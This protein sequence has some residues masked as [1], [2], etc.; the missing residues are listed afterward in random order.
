MART[1]LI[2]EDTLRQLERLTLVSRKLSTGHLRGERRSRRHGQSVDFADY[3]NYVTGDDLRFLDWKIYARLERLF[4]K[5]FLEEED[6]RVYILLDCS[7]SMVFGEPE[8]LLYAKRVAAALGYIC[9]SRMDSLSVYPFAG[10]MLERFGPRRGKVNGA[11]YF[12]FLE[13]V[14]PGGETGMGRV[15]RD[16]AR[17]IRA[18]GL[19]ILL[20][21]FLDFGGYEDGLGDLFGRGFEVVAMHLLSPEELQPDLVGDVRLVDCE[22]GRHTDVSVGRHLLDTY[23]ATLEAFCEGLRQH[24]IRRGGHYLLCS[25]EVPFDRLVLNVLMRRG[26]IQ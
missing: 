10:R 8:K 14:E 2:D 25:T 17:S 26:L 21:D 1:K 11:A 3:R 7:R 24:I 16:F 22:N 13:K 4:L 6:L 18:K 5:L 19:V 12:D 15:L 9:M 20:S 23:Q